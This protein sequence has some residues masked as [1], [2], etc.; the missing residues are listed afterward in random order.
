[1]Q[2]S[3]AQDSFALRQRVDPKSGQGELTIRGNT[4]IARRVDGDVTVTSGAVVVS[5][6]ITG[7]LYV[8]GGHVRVLGEVGGDVENLGGVVD[9]HGVVEGSVLGP[10][11]CT[12]IA[13]GAVVGATTSS[14]LNRR[15]IPL[16]N[17]ERFDSAGRWRV[18]AGLA[19]SAIGVAVIGLVLIGSNAD[20]SPAPGLTVVAVDRSSV[21]VAGKVEEPAVVDRTVDSTQPPAANAEEAEDELGEPAHS[22]FS[23]DPSYP[24]PRVCIPSPPPL[25]TCEQVGVTGFVVQG[26]DPHNFDSNGDGIGCDF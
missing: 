24:E 18:A 14:T 9:V 20:P 22:L 8:V 10:R 15:A 6:L 7:N 4:E 21:E 16:H 12:H 1:M 23:C 3:R 19:M 26:D 5:G 2:P 13:D 17:S 11:S 25:L